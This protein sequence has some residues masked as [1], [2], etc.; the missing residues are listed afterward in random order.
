MIS[1]TNS[2]PS[3]TIFLSN[4]TGDGSVNLTL[5][6]FSLT[7]AEIIPARVS[8]ESFLPA[9][10]L[11]YAKRATQRAAL[12][13]ISATLPS[14]LKNRHLKSADSDGSLNNKPSAPTEILR[15]QIRRTKVERSPT[16]RDKFRLSMIIKSLP[17]PLIL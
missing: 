10:P 12:P 3:I 15:A 14:E 11:R 13:H 2:R 17:L 7:S 6:T 4:L 9:I 8:K 16:L 5:G 1:N